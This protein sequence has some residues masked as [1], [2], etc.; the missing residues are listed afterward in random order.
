MG[1]GISDEESARRLLEA[2]LR[3]TVAGVVCELVRDDPPDIRCQVAEER[4][5]M[6]VTR[7]NQLELQDGRVKARG[8]ID[9]PLMEFGNQLGEATKSGRS[10]KYTLMLSGPASTAMWRA[11]KRQ[12]RNSV[13]GFVRSDALGEC[14]F[15]GGSI[16][17]HAEGSEWLV[18][19][20]P[21]E[22]A[23]TPDGAAAYD[24]SANI[25]AMLRHA[26][27]QKVSRLANLSG[28]DKT[29][30]ILLNA[31]FFGDDA[32][33]IGRALSRIIRE[34][35]EYQL[36]DFVFYVSQQRL[37]LVFAKRAGTASKPT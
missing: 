5:A 13:E 4:W 32:E 18:A 15:E 27:S 3:S 9:I 20:L 36:F 37:S 11:W 16:T 22:G 17:A 8:E 34:D 26:L 7:V 6:E 29:G 14:A 19:I 30:L 25:D 35:D 12:T 24:I 28:Y 21:R 31:Y 2:H 10:L 23:V 33:D 1:T